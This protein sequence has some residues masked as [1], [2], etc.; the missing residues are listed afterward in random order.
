MEG[1]EKKGKNERETREYEVGYTKGN[2][3]FT[4]QLAKPKIGLVATEAR[5]IVPLRVT[6]P[7]RL[8]HQKIHVYISG[9]RYTYV[10]FIHT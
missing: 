9:Y 6:E 8:H 4:D 5:H 2:S 3:K 1:S 7:Q 10:C